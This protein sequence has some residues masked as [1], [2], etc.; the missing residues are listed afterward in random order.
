MGTSLSQDAEGRPRRNCVPSSS[1]FN[2]QFVV[3]QAAQC[4]CSDPTVVWE[5]LS[6]AVAEAIWL[7]GLLLELMPSAPD[8]IKIY[9]NNKGAC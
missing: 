2:K 5:T 9:C 6:V 7:K 1:I 4:E 8:F 3:N